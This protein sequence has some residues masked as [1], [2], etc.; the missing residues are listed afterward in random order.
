MTHHQQ[1]VVTL[2]QQRHLGLIGRCYPPIGSIGSRG[3]GIRIGGIGRRTGITHHTTP[4]VRHYTGSIG[5]HIHR[6]FARYI[7]QHPVVIIQWIVGYY[8]KAQYTSLKAMKLIPERILIQINNTILTRHRN[9][10]PITDRNTILYKSRCTTNRY[11][12]RRRLSLQSTRPLRHCI[13]CN[14]CYN[15]CYEYCSQHCLIRN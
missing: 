1:V 7:K 8:Q 4:V 2:Q 3:T 15:K 10:R 13:T 6:V 5:I 12:Q 9:G 11:C 14:E